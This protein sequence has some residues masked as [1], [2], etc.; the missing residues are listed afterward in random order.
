MC[1]HN[2][3]N[4]V[5]N[6]YTFNTVYNTMYIHVCVRVCIYRVSAP[7]KRVVDDLWNASEH[8]AHNGCFAHTQSKL[9]RNAF[10]LKIRALQKI[11]IKNINKKKK[12]KKC[13][14]E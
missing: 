3:H 2:L 4:T 5:R 12:N 13:D 14:C 6:L 8:I 10:L 7:T 9:N 1:V 11:K